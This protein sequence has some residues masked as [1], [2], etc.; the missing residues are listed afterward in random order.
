MKKK[1]ATIE[2]EEGVEEEVEVVVAVGITEDGDLA[3]SVSHIVLSF[4]NFV[5]LFVDC[6]DTIHFL[7]TR[8]F[9]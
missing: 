5:F 2:E 3:N 1:G 4:H 9:G 6:V 8:I 7:F